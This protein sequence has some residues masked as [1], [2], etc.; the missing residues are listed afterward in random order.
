MTD[1]VIILVHEEE[2]EK[3]SCMRCIHRQ[4]DPKLMRYPVIKCRKCGGALFADFGATCKD[5]EGC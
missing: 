4:Q 5:F 1:H 2:L 3:H